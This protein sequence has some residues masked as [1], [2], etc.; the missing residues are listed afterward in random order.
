V[1][2][3][4]LL[5]RAGQLAIGAGLL[6]V[7]PAWAEVGSSGPTSAQLKVLAR[8]IHGK[9]VTPSS[10]GYAQDRLVFDTRFNS[11]RPKAIVY[12]ESTSDVQKTVAWARKYGVR[13][14]PRSGGHSYAGYSTTSSGVIVD[15]SRLNY[16]QAH[17][18]GT[19]LIG[20]G[21][22]L[23]SIYSKLWAQH[24]MIPGGSCPTV[25]IGGLAQ[26]GGHGWSGRKFGLT[27][28]SIEQLTIVTA[29]GKV[30]VCNAH[31][32]SDLYWACRGGGGGN[33]G[34]VTNFTFKTYQ[35]GN[36][37]TF[38]ITWPWS[39]A[40]RVVKAWQAWAPHATPNLGL[41]VVVLQSGST[42]SISASGQFFGSASALRSLIRPLTN[43]GA[44]SV[45][46]TPRTFM[47]AVLLYAG[48][49]SVSACLKPQRQAFKAKSDYCQKPLSPAGINTML[50][51]IEAFGR[52]PSAGA[53][54]MILDSYGGAINKVAPA[55][56]AF[57]HRDMLFSMQYYGTPGS[58]GDISMLNKFHAAMK[59]YVSGYA[60]QNYI[61]PQEPNWQHAYYGTNYPRLV[62]IKKKYDPSNF[63]RFAQ[64]IRLNT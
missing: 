32:N 36:V 64:S 42:P 4:E 12:V 55:A 45:S 18:G 57:A 50:R 22:P 56:T 6:G 5:E 16:V 10:S 1:D 23:I 37:S 46:I 28:D 7:S 31:Q 13:L 3:R 43:V 40:A 62:S 63:F 8:Q 60:Y 26:G 17:A 24:R 30:L 39:Q 35:V 33:F 47:G 11:A 41:S 20:A 44:P 49:S 27:S 29:G 52:S 21:A 19:A 53:V 14:V 54:A 25:G 61:D 58:A 34:I 15:V 48:C 38:Y 51:A 59:P 9:V 2:R